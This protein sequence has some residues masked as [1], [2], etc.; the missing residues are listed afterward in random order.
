MTDQLIPRWIVRR[1]YRPVQPDVEQE[2]RVQRLLYSERRVVERVERHRPHVVK[3]VEG[4]PNLVAMD[5]DSHRRL[6]LGEDV[7]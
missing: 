5:R 1:L 6:S 2:R 7:H 4:Y 3:T